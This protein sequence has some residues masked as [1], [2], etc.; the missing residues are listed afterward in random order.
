MK[1]KFFCVLCT[2]LSFIL[3]SPLSFFHSLFFAL[4]EAH[5]MNSRCLMIEIDQCAD[6]KP[7]CSD[8]RLCLAYFGT[9]ACLMVEKIKDVCRIL[10][11]VR[12][13]I[14]RLDYVIFALVVRMLQILLSGEECMCRIRFFFFLLKSANLHL[15]NVF[16]DVFIPCHARNILLN[17]F[18]RAKWILL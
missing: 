11:N 16:S 2:T 3:L 7:C 12:V 8:L 13:L 1:D 15:T 5:N 17:N 6:R 18:M 14:F 9:L 4:I 10:F